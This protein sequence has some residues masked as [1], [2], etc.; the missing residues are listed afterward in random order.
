MPSE[1][2]NNQNK[3]SEKIKIVNHDRVASS[4]KLHEMF[5][6][7][8]KENQIFNKSG[9]EINKIMESIPEEDRDLARYEYNK[10]KSAKEAIRGVVEDIKIKKI[11]KDIELF[12]K[13]LEDLKNNR[14]KIT[15]SQEKRFA[16][17]GK[18]INTHEV[19]S[20]KSSTKKRAGIFLKDNLIGRINDIADVKNYE[21][22]LYITTNKL[23]RY[24]S[25]EDLLNKLNLK[26]ITLQGLAIIID[27][28]SELLNGALDL[29]SPIN[30]DIYNI[31]LI[32]IDNKVIPVEI[33]YDPTSKL[34]ILGEYTDEV[35][36]KDFL[37]GGNIISG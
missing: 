19:L 13:K 26:P 3:V 27:S 21:K 37:T 5:P 36:E 16:L 20:S 29:K 1:N 23:D 35:G 14:N 32:N 30:I 25:K 15:L 34:Y 10:G 28:Q 8:F 22:G 17:D 18:Y 2:I 33:N 6:N 7:F 24:I 12:T 9:E 31:V 11:D 4:K